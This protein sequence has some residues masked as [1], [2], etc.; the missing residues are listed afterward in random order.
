MEVT[1]R[2]ADADDAASLDVLRAQALKAA[3]QTDYDRKTVGELVAT[4][5]AELSS[6]IDD[7]RY[8]VVVAETE[9]TIVAYA[10][11]DRQDGELVTIMTSPDYQ[12]SGFASAVLDRIETRVADAG[13][14]TLSATVPDPALAFF[15]ARGFDSAET[16]T[17]HNLPANRVRKSL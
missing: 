15:R 4:V 12:R 16:A 5:D 11:A 9:I 17:W 1:I 3:L 10:V 2:Q 14:E 13:H 8:L 7:D 6:R